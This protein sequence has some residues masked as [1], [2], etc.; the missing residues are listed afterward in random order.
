[1]HD[2]ILIIFFDGFENAL[3]AVFFRRIFSEGFVVGH[4]L[5]SHETGFGVKGF[6]DPLLLRTHFFV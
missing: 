4:D 3:V 2:R 6:A 5:V 1:M